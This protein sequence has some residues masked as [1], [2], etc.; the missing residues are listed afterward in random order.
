MPF[1]LFV[2]ERP[3]L[4]RVYRVSHAKLTEPLSLHSPAKFHEHCPSKNITLVPYL[5]NRMTRT[6]YSISLFLGIYFEFFIRFFK[7]E[8]HMA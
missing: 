5:S 3:K 1:I 6:I 2:A 7:T 4:K 8:R